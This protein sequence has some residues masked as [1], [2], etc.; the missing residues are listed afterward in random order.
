MEILGN[1]L[2]FRKKLHSTLYFVRDNELEAMS[3]LKNEDE[4]VAN[5]RMVQ[6]C[7]SYVLE[8]VSMRTSRF[9]W[10]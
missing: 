2:A 6:G 3:D 4:S 8:R 5:T 9:V 1:L 10:S 7:N